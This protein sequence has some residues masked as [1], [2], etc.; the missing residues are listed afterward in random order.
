M[1]QRQPELLIGGLEY[2][3]S[4]CL[5]VGSFTDSIIHSDIASNAEKRVALVSDQLKS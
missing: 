4:P 1:V 3:P 5:Q 2:S